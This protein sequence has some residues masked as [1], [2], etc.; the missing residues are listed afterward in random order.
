MAK[1]TGRNDR[2]AEKSS[3]EGNYSENCL[4]SYRS[5]IAWDRDFRDIF[6][7]RKGGRARE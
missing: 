4:C 7:F 5:G 6:I 3:M 1:G 2:Q